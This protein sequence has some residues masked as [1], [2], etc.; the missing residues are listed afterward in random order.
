MVTM[1]NLTGKKQNKSLVT[2]I[3]KRKKMT[4]G[5]SGTLS[6][7]RTHIQ[8][9][10]KRLM[11]TDLCVHQG[12]AITDRCEVHYRY[13]R[14]HD[15]SLPTQ[16]SFLQRDSS[17]EYLKI[18]TKKERWEYKHLCV[19]CDLRLLQMN[20][21]INFKFAV[22]IPSSV[23]QKLKNNLERRSVCECAGKLNS[24]PSALFCTLSQRKLQRQYSPQCTM[25]SYSN[26]LHL[27]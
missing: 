5:C 15:P 9:A 8:T 22:I 4:T 20:A 25:A 2:N 7:A 1:V 10:S 6:L 16:T 19:Q 14:S 24:H 21:N 18:Q 23:P 27:H 26:P 3:K 13:N 17:R 12:A 11:Y